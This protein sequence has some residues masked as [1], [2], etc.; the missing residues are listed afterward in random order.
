MNAKIKLFLILALF[1]NSYLHATVDEFSFQNGTLHYKENRLN[2]SFVINEKNFRIEGGVLVDIIK[3]PYGMQEIIKIISE[4]GA[5]E[6]WLF[7]HASKEKLQK[8]DILPMEYNVAWSSSEYIVASRFKMGASNNIIYNINSE[9][10]TIIKSEN[11]NNLVYFN[12][13]MLYCVYFVFPNNHI[14]IKNLNSEYKEVFDINFSYKHYTEALQMIKKVIIDENILF[15]EV[16]QS[17]EIKVFQYQ[18]H[19]QQSLTKEA[20]K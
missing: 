19:N 13:E 12:P 6:L 8:I 17:S 5:M 9:H 16:K 20:I 10:S 15:V 4:N 14:I 2:T 3:S 1:L 11:I 7:D 18:L